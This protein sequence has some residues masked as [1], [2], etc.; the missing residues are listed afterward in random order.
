MSSGRWIRK[1][2]GA[3]SV[4]LGGLSLGF[5]LGSDG[6][7]TL[8][9][10]QEGDRLARSKDSP[11]HN[12][13]NF[14]NAAAPSIPKVDGA[15]MWSEYRKAFTEGRQKQPPHPI[16]RHEV[17]RS[18]HPPAPAS[19]VRLTW[20]GH[21]SVLIE[22]D[23]SRVLTDPMFSNRA[24]P[25]QWAGPK[26]FQPAA[27][28]VD[29]LPEV[30]AVVISHDHYDHLDYETIR[31]L[32]E[33]TS[34]T[35][36]VPLGVGAH[37]ELW[38]I[39]PERIREMDWWEEAEV[40][41][42]LTL[43]ATP[44][45]HFSGRG[46]GDRNHTLWA[47]WAV[48]GD[49]HRVWFS[50]DTGYTDLFKDIGERLGPFDAAL[51]ESGAYNPAWPSVHML[52][53]HFGQAAE[54]VRAKNVLPIHWGTFDLSSHAWNAPPEEMLLQGQKRGFR[55]MTPELGAPMDVSQAEE[56]TAWWRELKADGAAAVVGGDRRGPAAKL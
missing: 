51:V 14:Y 4:L 45:Q 11:Q 47:S 21:S 32:G 54:A 35:F 24:S 16:P 26:R 56:S 50:G 15:T 44:S 9:G 3:V 31:Q 30:D 17:S 28:T 53:E 29:S 10:E 8:G 20:L 43:I 6:L 52:P 12:G 38:G 34:V 39:P 33:Q 41:Q 5:L 55:V 23:G 27:T 48:V 13:K 25:V 19:G 46:L 40:N 36:F 18:F 7:A 1:G 2:L 49:E 37:L 42:R 22:V